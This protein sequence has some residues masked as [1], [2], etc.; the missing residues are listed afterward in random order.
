M[1]RVVGE[2]FAIGGLG[3]GELTV[4]VQ[5]QGPVEGRAG[6]PTLSAKIHGKPSV[7]PAFRSDSPTGGFRLPAQAVVIP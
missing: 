5:L 7:E 2:D 1:V 3:L 4:G 6:I